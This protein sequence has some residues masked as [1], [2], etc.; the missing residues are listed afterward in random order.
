[1]LQRLTGVGVFKTGIKLAHPSFST[2]FLSSQKTHRVYAL[3]IVCKG[4]ARTL[5]P[6]LFLTS[7]PAQAPLR[8]ST[9]YQHDGRLFNTGSKT[10]QNIVTKL[11]QR[12]YPGEI[13]YT[14]ESPRSPIY[15]WG[16]NTS[17]EHR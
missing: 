3:S 12:K 8:L 11:E 7:P 9:R 2:I 4:W 5:S 14:Y 17:Y 15:I 13:M 1:M 10:W 16:V 6:S